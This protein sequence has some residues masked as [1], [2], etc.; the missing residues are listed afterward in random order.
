MDIPTHDLLRPPLSPACTPLLNP[1]PFPWGYFT[2]PD[3][4]KTFL[5]EGSCASQTW[6]QICVASGKS[7]NLSEPSCN[8]QNGNKVSSPLRV[9]G[10]NGEGR[11]WP[12]GQRWRGR[13]VQI[14]GC[15]EGRQ[16]AAVTR[17]GSSGWWR[18]WVCGQC[19]HEG[20]AGSRTSGQG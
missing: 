9:V 6:A 1:P 15:R 10:I 20:Q 19:P 3:P 16:Q 13:A 8:L 17:S 11:H 7:L 5:P 18:S 12:A 14:D 4:G 2:L